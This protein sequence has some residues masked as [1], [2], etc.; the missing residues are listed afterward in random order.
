MLVM[1]VGSTTL[2]GGIIFML[3]RPC[4]LNSKSLESPSLTL[5]GGVWGGVDTLNFT[6]H[7]LM[8]FYLTTTLQPV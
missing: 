4:M 6:I 2:N 7:H 1:L 3:I 8:Q 5:R